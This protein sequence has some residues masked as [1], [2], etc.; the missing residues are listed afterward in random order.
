MVG[1]L[2]RQTEK[3]QPYPTLYVANYC[4]YTQD[5]NFQNASKEHYATER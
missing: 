2:T 3:M 5:E 1:M 4:V